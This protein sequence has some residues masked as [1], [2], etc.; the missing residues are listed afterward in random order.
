MIQLGD[1]LMAIEGPIRLSVF[2]VMLIALVTWELAAP[3]RRQDIPRVLRWTNNI[4][5]VVVDTL[6]LRLTFPVLAV[7]FAVHASAKGWGLFNA[8]AVPEWLAVV[9]SVLVLDLVIYFQHVV[10]HKVPVLWRL[11]RMHHSDQEC[12]ATTG[13]RFHPVEIAI[14]MAIKLLVVAALGA[15]ALAVLLFEV[16]LNATSL[17]NHA[18]IRL[19]RWLDRRL[20]WVVVTPDMHRVHHS[21]LPVETNSNFG[22]NVPWW[23]RLFGT[24][25]ASPLHGHRDMRL[26][27]ELFR[28]PRDQWLDR[29]LVQPFLNGQGRGPDDK[30]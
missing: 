4:A 12:D 25:R 15:P 22:F 3:R 26:G 9:L 18:N 29:M 8:V 21:V 2:A 24:Y 20:R 11:H 23:D 5:L 30:A 27:I 10:F 16:M 1:T 28:T 13:L 7:G 6:I 17:F 19:S 14:S